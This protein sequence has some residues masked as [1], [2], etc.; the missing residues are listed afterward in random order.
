MPRN[1]TGWHADIR[2]KSTA[3]PVMLGLSLGLKA[4]IFAFGLDLLPD[5]LT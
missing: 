3:S 5:N 2:I 4:K 1:E